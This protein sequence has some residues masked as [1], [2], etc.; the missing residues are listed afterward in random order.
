MQVR[1]ESRAA[2]WQ[3]DLSRPGGCL[4]F[5]PMTADK[6]AVFRS[7]QYPGLVVKMSTALSDL[8]FEVISMQHFHSFPKSDI[9]ARVPWT[10]SPF[11]L[12]CHGQPM[13]AFVQQRIAGA[14]VKPRHM[15]WALS[16]LQDSHLLSLSL[17]LSCR[18]CTR[19]YTQSR[20]RRDMA[21]VAAKDLRA[22]AAAVQKVGWIEDLQFMASQTTGEL[23][24]IDTSMPHAPGASLVNKYIATRQAVEL[25]TLALAL[26]LSA[27]KSLEALLPNLQPLLLCRGVCLLGCNFTGLPADTMDPLGALRKTSDENVR[28]VVQALDRAGRA[29]ARLDAQAAHL[30]KARQD[31]SCRSCMSRKHKHEMD[32]DERAALCDCAYSVWHANFRRE[33]DRAMAACALEATCARTSDPEDPELRH[34]GLYSLTPAIGFPHFKQ[35]IGVAPPLSAANRLAI[36]FYDKREGLSNREKIGM[37]DGPV[38]VV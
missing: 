20:L 26:L 29:L 9:W 21:M 3:A 17:S 28:A 18:N 15:R 2:A 6:K 14:L 16:D 24:L 34:R 19:N 4:A 5:L 38:F 22:W 13:F 11:A 36:V 8:L 10:G 33:C 37:V 12:D 35:H 32:S 23:W 31:A 30:P 27:S 25:L 7:P 1:M